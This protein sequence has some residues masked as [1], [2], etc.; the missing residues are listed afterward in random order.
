MVG[1]NITQMV[2][3]IDPS[4]NNGGSTAASR[5]GTWTV[6][7]GETT[8][9]S[10]SG[11]ITT[12]LT[13]VYVGYFD[14]STGMLTLEF[15]DP[16]TYNGGNLLLDLQHSAASWNRWYFLGVAATDTYYGYSGSQDFLPK[17]T[18]SYENP[19]AC[20][21]PSGVTIAGVTATTATISWTI[22]T[23]QTATYTITNGS[24]INETT[25]SG[26]S[27][28]TLEG[29]TPQTTYSGLTITANCGGAG[30]SEAA[31]V[32]TIRT[33]AIPVNLPYS[34]GFEAG[35]DVNWEYTQGTTNI[36]TVGS[37]TNNG[38][39]NALYISNDNGASNAYSNGTSAISYACRLFNFSQDGDYAV[40][41]DWNANGENNWDYLRA[42]LAPGNAELTADQLPDHTTGMSSYTTT[43]PDGWI[44]LGNGQMSLSTD[45]QNVQL[46]A[47][48]ITAGNYYLVFMWGNDGSGGS[49]PPAAIDNV[50][51][52]RITCPAP[53][54]LTLDPASLTAT[55]ATISWTPR[56][57]ETSWLMR[58]N[59]GTWQT[60]TAATQTLTLEPN[61]EYT[62]Q[63]RAFCGVGDTSLTISGTFRT[64]CLD[65]ATA[66]LP[67]TMGFQPSEI[68]D[69]ACWAVGS[70][71]TTYPVLTLVGHTG[72]TSLQIR[73]YNNSSYYP[74]S[75]Y[76][77]W[78]TLPKFEA[79]VNTLQMSFWMKYNSSYSSSKLRVGVMTDPSDPSTFTQIEEISATDSWTL[80]DVEFDTYTGNGNYI[81]LMVPQPTSTYT[82]YQVLVDDISVELIPAC[83]K[84]KN[85]T[86]T[87]NGTTVSTSWT[88]REGQNLWEVAV[89]AKDSTVVRSEEVEETTFAFAGLKGNTDYIVRVQ[90]NCGTDGMGTPA[91]ADVHTDPEV[92][93]IDPQH[94][95]YCR[96]EDVDQYESQ[97]VLNNPSNNTTDHWTIGTDATTTGN[98]LY[99]TDDELGTYHYTT[100]GYSYKRTYALMNVL[101]G[102]GHN[103]YE[104]SFDIKSNSNNSNHYVKVYLL[105]ASY[106]ISA[107]STPSTSASNCLAYLP[108]LYNVS[109]W[110]TLSGVFETNNEEPTQYRLVVMWY[111]YGTA[112]G[113]PAAIDNVMLKQNSCFR[114]TG[115]DTVGEPTANSITLTWT[116][117]NESNPGQWQV[118]WSENSGFDPDVAKGRSG[119]K[120]TENNP[121]VVTG[122]KHSTTYFFSVRSKCSDFSA[123][124]EKYSF[125]T[126][127]GAYTSN[128][129]PL[130]ENFDSYTSGLPACWTAVGGGN[131]QVRSGSAYSGSYKLDFRGVAGN[132]IVA[133]PVI[134]AGSDTLIM[135][136]YTKP[137]SNSYANCGQF[138]VGYITDLTDS[139]TFHALATYD[140]SDWA[141]NAY[142][143]REVNLVNLPAG[144]HPAFR[145][146]SPV[147]NYYWYVDDLNIDIKADQVVL[148]NSGEQTL[149]NSIVKPTIETSTGSYKRN[150][151]RTYVIRPADNGKALNVSGSVDLDLG[152]TL[153][154]YEGIGDNKV[155]KGEYTNTTATLNLIKSTVADWAVNNAI[156]LVFRTNGSESGIHTGFALK[157][158]C[159]CPAGKRVD[160]TG[161]EAAGHYDFVMSDGTLSLPNDNHAY[162]DNASDLEYDF[163]DVYQAVVGG[164][165]SV[166]LHHIV[167]V[168]PYYTINKDDNLCAGKTYQ[169]IDTTLATGGIYTRTG[170]T[171][172][173]ADSTVTVN[174]QQRSN[175]TI[176]LRYENM[177]VNVVNNFCEGNNMD[178]EARS[179]SS[180]VRFMW[181]DSTFGATRTVTPLGASTYTVQATDTIYGCVS[182]VATLNVTTVPSPMPVISANKTEICAGDTVVLTVSDTNN[183][184]GVT[185][186]W[187]TGETGSSIT[188]VPTTVPVTEYSV[189][190]ATA[191]CENVATKSITVNALPQVAITAS[192]NAICLGD[193][194][195]FTAETVLGYTYQWANGTTGTVNAFVP[196]GVGSL[197]TTLTVTDQKACVNTL[198]NTPVVVRPSYDNAV[199]AVECV[200]K[201]PYIFGN[202]TSTSI[203][204]LDTDGV[205]Y[206]TFTLATGCDSVVTLTFSVQDT[207][208]YNS[209]REYC[210]GT[211]FSFGDSLY[212]HDYVAT[213][214]TT[215]SYFDT[216]GACPAYYNL[217]VTVHPTYS[218]DIVNSVCDSLV[219][220]DSV[221]T[222]TGDYTQHL[223]TNYNCD[224]TVNLAL[225]VRYSNSYTDVKDVCDKLN[226]HGTTYTEPVTGPTFTTKNVAGC[227]S[228]VTLDLAVVRH[229]TVGYDVQNICQTLTYTWVNNMTYTMSELDSNIAF[230]LP[231]PNAQGCDTTAI[232]LLSLNPATDTLNLDTVRVCDEFVED[233]LGCDGQPV[234]ASFR[235]PGLYAYRVAQDGKIAYKQ[236]Y[237][238]VKT[239]V[240][241][242]VTVTACAPYKWNKT[243]ELYFRDTTVAYGGAECADTM[244]VLHYTAIQPEVRYAYD[245]ICSMED[246]T[247]LPYYSQQ[248]EAPVTQEVSV[249]DVLPLVDREDNITDIVAG[250]YR[251]AYHNDTAAFDKDDNHCY[252]YDTLV[253]TVNQQFVETLDSLF[254]CESAFT[255]STD[256]I[257]QPYYGQM[258]YPIADAAHDTVFYLTLGNGSY[259]DETGAYECSQNFSLPTTTGCDSLIKV[260]YVV[261]PTV[262]SYTDQQVESMEFTWKE[263]GKTYEFVDSTATVMTI[264]L[265]PGTRTVKRNFYTDTVVFA[266]A[267][268]HNGYEGHE[269]QCDSVLY[270]NLFI[271]D[272]IRDVLEN[273]THCNPASYVFNGQTYYESHTFTED[274]VMDWNGKAMPVRRYWIHNIGEF[275]WGDK[276][277]VS[278]DPYAANNV[279]NDTL[280]ATGDYT[281]RYAAIS[282]CDS[283][284]E[285]HF[286]K[287][288]T[289]GVALCDTTL[290]TFSVY[291]LSLDTAALDSLRALPASEY[292]HGV[293]YYAYRVD[294]ADVDTLI[295]IAF[296]KGSFEH[297]VPVAP[298]ACDL[299]TWID[300]ITYTQD[301]D[302]VVYNY[303]DVYGCPSAD[304]LFLTL[305]HNSNHSDT[306]VACDSLKWYGK[307]YDS[308]G[309]Y[310]AKY[311]ATND[312]PSVDTLHLTIN[313]RKDTLMHVVAC[314]EYVWEN[315][316][317]YVVYSETGAYIEQNDS[318]VFTAQPGDTVTDSVIAWRI[319][320]ACYT[321]DTLVVTVKSHSER[322][323]ENVVNAAAYTYGGVQYTIPAGEHDTVIGPFEYT[324]T[325]PAA[326]GCDSIEFM[327]VHLYNGVNHTVDVANHCG[328]FTWTDSITATGDTIWLGNNHIYTYLTPAER[329]AAPLGS[330][331]YFD[332]T[333]NDYVYTNPVVYDTFEDGGFRN[334][335]VLYLTLS[336][337]KVAY[338]T[339][340]VAVPLSWN[341]YAFKPAYDTTKTITLDL[342]GYT[343]DNVTKD[344]AFV[345][346]DAYGHSVGAYCDSINYITLNLR[347]NYAKDSVIVCATTDSVVFGDTT[348]YLALEMDNTA[349]TVSHLYENLV[350]NADTLTE[351]HTDLKVTWRMLIDTTVYDTACYKKTYTFTDSVYTKSVV[352]GVDN[353]IVEHVANNCDKLVYHFLTIFT[354]TTATDIDTVCGNTYEWRRHDDSVFTAS[355]RY[356][357]KIDSQ[358]FVN[359][360]KCEAIDSLIL[361]LIAEPTIPEAEEFCD[362]WTYTYFNYLTGKDSTIGPLTMADTNAG[363]SVYHIVFEY[364]YN[365]QDQLN[366]VMEGDIIFNVKNGSV[367]DTAITVI[368]NSYKFSFSDSVYTASASDIDDTLSV[369][370]VEGCDSI[371]RWDLT[372]IPFKTKVEDYTA[373][374]RFVWERNGHTYQF[375]TVTGHLYYDLTDDSVITVAPAVTVEDTIYQLN[376]T[377]NESAIGYM[378][379]TIL[380]SQNRDGFVDN[381]DRRVIYWDYT[382]FT[383]DS[384]VNAVVNVSDVP[385]T[386]DSVV[387]YT[388]EVIYNFDVDSTVFCGSEAGKPFTW[389][390]ITVN[391]PAQGQ[392][393]FMEVV[394]NEGGITEHV[395]QNR[396]FTRED[397]VLNIFD[398]VCDQLN[399]NGHIFTETR[400]DTTI[401]LYH[402]DTIKNAN[403]CDTIV[404]L[405]L[406]VNKN[407]G[408]LY[409]AAQCDSLL[410]WN[411]GTEVKGDSLW[412]Y[413][414]DTLTWSY[415]DANKCASIDS[416]ALTIYKPESKDTVV[417]LCVDAD[418]T[419]VWNA[420]A[421]PTIHTKD[422][423]VPVTMPTGVAQFKDT[424]Y[425]DVY[426]SAH[427]CNSVDT[428]YLT[429]NL[430]YNVQVDT[431]VSESFPYHFADGHDTLLIA[432]GNLVDH[433]DS[434]ANGCDS[435]VAINVHIGNTYNAVDD[436]VVCHDFTWKDD[437][438]YVWISATERA[439]HTVSGMAPLYKT[440][441]GRYVYF[442]PTYTK[443]NNF[444]TNNWDSVFVLR[445][446]LTENYYGNDEITFNVSDE[447]LNYGI[448]NETAATVLTEDYSA[449]NNFWT[450][451]TAY[452]YELHFGATVSTGHYCDSII[453]LTVN[454]HNN[455]VNAGPDAICAYEATYTWHDSTYVMRTDSAA[456]TTFDTIY[457]ND[458]TNNTVQYR[459]LTRKPVSNSVERREACDYYTWNGMPFGEEDLLGSGQTETYRNTKVFTAENGCDSIVS[460]VLTLHYNAT[461][462]TPFV[463]ACDSATYTFTAKLDTATVT[464]K[465]NASV[466][467]SLVWQTAYAGYTMKC[468]SV[469]YVQVSVVTSIDSIFTVAACDEYTWHNKTYKKDT[470]VSFGPKNNEKEFTDELFGRSTFCPVK[471]SL[472]LDIKN[473]SNHLI[474]DDTVCDFYAT[475]TNFYK[476]NL[477]NVSRLSSW[478]DADGVMPNDT[479][480]YTDGLEFDTL[481]SNFGE[482][483]TTSGVYWHLYT[484]NDGCHSIDTLILNV[485]YNSNSKPVLAEAC[486]T[487]RYEKVYPH[488]VKIGT[489]A[490]AHDTT[491]VD[492]FSFVSTQSD[493]VLFEYIALNGCPSVDTLVFTVNHKVDTTF[494][495][496]ACDTWT[497]NGHTV[498]NSK[499]YILDT[500]LVDT[501]QNASITGC[502]SIVTINLSVGHGNGVAYQTEVACGHYDWVVNDSLVGTFT[503]SINTSFVSRNGAANYCDS[504]VYLRLTIAEPGIYL[505]TTVNEAALPFVWYGNEYTEAGIYRD[506]LAGDGSNCDSIAELHLAIRN[507]VV[508]NE[509]RCF[510]TKIFNMYGFTFDSAALSVPGVISAYNADSTV[511]LNLTVGPKNTSYVT[512]VDTVACDSYDWARYVD[513]V[514]LT[515]SG[516]YTYWYLDTVNVDPQGCYKVD[517]L[518]LTVVRNLGVK[519]EVYTCSAYNWRGNEYTESGEYY[520]QFTDTNNCAAADTLVLT[521]NGAGVATSFDTAACGSFVWDGFV[522]T[523]SGSYSRTYGSVDDCDSVVTMNLTITDQVF[524]SIAKLSCGSYTWNGITYNESGTYTQ[525]FEAENGCDSVV[526]L[527]LIVGTVASGDTAA[528]A[529]GSFEWFGETYTTSGVYTHTFVADETCDSVVTLTLT[530]N[531]PVTSTETV[532]ACG[533]YTWNDVT[534]TESG[535]YTDTLTAVNGCDSIVTLNLTINEPIDII[536]SVVACDSYTWFDVAYTTS[537]TYTHDITDANGCAATATLGLTIHNSVTNTISAQNCVSYTWND[538]TYYGS[539]SYT[540]SFQTVHGCDSTVTLNLTINQPTTGSE[541]IE[542]CTDITWHGQTISTSG[543]YTYTTVNA[544]GCDSVVTLFF[545]RLQSVAVTVNATACDSYTWNGTTYTTSGTY[546]YNTTGTNGCDSLTTLVLTINE[547]RNTNIS[548]SACESYSWNDQEYTTS[549]TYQQTL[550]ARNGCDSI[551]TLTLTVNHDAYSTVTDE[552][553]GSYFWNGEEYTTSGT[554]LYITTTTAGCDSI[555][556]LNLTVNQPVYTNLTITADGS[557]NWNGEVY[558]ESGIYTYTTTAA[559]GCDSTVTLDLTVNPIYNVTLVSANETMGTVSESGAIVE[560]GYFTAVATPKEGYEF[561]EWKNGNVTVSTNATYVF[562]VT[563]DVTLTAVFQVKTVG[564]ED[565]DMDNVTIYSSNSTIYV[566][567]VEGHDV[568]V[569]DV[570]GRMMDRQLNAADAI[571]FRMTATGVYLV[572]VGNAPAKR[573][574]VV[575]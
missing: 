102:A 280:T 39:S 213:T 232:L 287:V 340:P 204:Q 452:H 565:V 114:P 415:L 516:I 177:P 317:G 241:A 518:Y 160:S 81:A 552:A 41:F 555:V 135:S 451:D 273:E 311:T 542:S 29:L 380:L 4:G 211:A 557:Y 503:E 146:R 573:V 359:G 390:G 463:V 77:T 561:V 186:T 299:F 458:T 26:A 525:T 418:Y 90:A 277:L 469:E 363:D 381:S 207:A 149:C 545:T 392:N 483:I 8:A 320:D 497:W 150:L 234:M 498:T 422:Y 464:R 492:T 350:T 257:G 107:T 295:T 568:Y 394:L 300:G 269:M 562:Q 36:W 163:N 367:Y 88:G 218:I 136:F 60:V 166:E 32:P 108:N 247:F 349:D 336:N 406:V 133:L 111:D 407:S 86:A 391:A 442:A 514:T 339:V 24:T 169:L 105:K 28:Y 543:A 550:T 71:N 548:E 89:L 526:T 419:Y 345:Y 286:T 540:Q 100:S 334:V 413:D 142:E 522:Y 569:Y 476:V 220:N 369:K 7:L 414:S 297:V 179:N 99:V 421:T 382:D 271:F 551:V 292:E 254:L 66:D 124:S 537:G 519:T 488:T 319:Y 357:L 366:C 58:L 270:L 229:S 200:D 370:N 209:F 374:G 267:I 513:T 6:S 116:D 290:R 10:L 315:Y 43:T 132:D 192:A 248:Y 434:V 1:K 17:T 501:L 471:D 205:Y 183:L 2:F 330:A 474:A 68:D 52:A 159:D 258:V 303:T 294:T 494:S 326:N 151:N 281:L 559:N 347:Y 208:T 138:D 83:R 193:S 541:T 118:A 448:H 293:H 296:S 180:A 20:S 467:D 465:Y 198:T 78:V 35:Q 325:A 477:I 430:N 76:Y 222:A 342:S 101:L 351:M 260:D 194:V 145:H 457:W 456:Y 115:L 393:D 316:A 44:D 547:T 323:W 528:T 318:L 51:I 546:T 504:T 162:D 55:S 181:D 244:Y 259:N 511:L 23:G 417:T 472:V 253:L 164:C 128:D 195:T 129:L 261:F 215:I 416:L 427:S 507:T 360:W 425:S 553:C 34:T 187:S 178:L 112:D 190:A 433:F 48:E 530:I 67:Y 157:L 356:G 352:E 535:V 27:S 131:P 31:N 156:T 140:R 388:I 210:Y 312:C 558:T 22:P 499:S 256:T 153:R 355:G 113:T 167:T 479:S 327:T 298:E 201:L 549:G 454:V 184:A 3:Y 18:F 440:S 219:W 354:P 423:D 337:V 95:Y 91:Y 335:Y 250:T 386:C 372:L 450:A 539:G 45:W 143:L 470:N 402:L 481:Y 206:N 566:K 444:A 556:T 500:V 368:G 283:I 533:S 239:T 173:G 480:V 161:I 275:V 144:A 120:M 33:T 484:N 47:D 473:R 242:P 383:N 106:N 570:N 461:D 217:Y 38:G 155:L 284:V 65:I 304:T 70:S 288:D 446:T 289:I 72:D 412:H 324:V 491:I 387:Y 321:A 191:T 197:T 62:I 12:T 575:R 15:D 396:L 199:E 202:E 152:D 437:T 196:A 92:V 54:N 523:E 212:R 5:L 567:G 486:D 246:Y 371:V 364:A 53:G 245:T 63:V 141:A 328:D 527:T 353:P 506:T 278:S 431:F 172:Y 255:L 75:N 445:L 361:T 46:S 435:T 268:E 509:F 123:W 544:A 50:S 399:F 524:D 405:Y 87:A 302:S 322:H 532:T 225:T 429:L 13:Q 262:E 14:C 341:S 57:G 56:G 243:G 249:T 237:L 61:T 189:T 40:S 571:E 560:N 122:L 487:F 395:K 127:C 447:V 276:Y 362:T 216:L 274:D 97:W 279:D 98:S 69:L 520:F 333:A 119:L 16:Y 265:N 126:A 221:Y 185:F 93:T 401:G 310:T 329:T 158:Q 104:Y 377:L 376:L 531:Q 42:W 348:L 226:W 82:Y 426:A 30:S 64:P 358:E 574:V 147:T 252:I 224:S 384:V 346:E 176:A 240:V 25:A 134:N 515:E 203:Q 400:S 301:T 49:Q 505:D 117:N 308:T 420:T 11:L 485:N 554:Y 305:M 19:P 227:D 512:S 96:F 174:L 165:D 130:T 171:I 343:R 21:K 389:E 534:L 74:S 94:P 490:S 344:T 309:V 282:G 272:T 493:S 139:A 235:N 517:S 332:R 411:L 439:E 468:R 214:D 466:L 521:I 572:K 233:T 375:D 313:T 398:T 478:M 331:L 263:N 397:I 168:H 73:S 285:M 432:D 564:I 385:G 9:T 148:D 379:T 460:L 404:H 502:D 182:P 538:Q 251:I 175:P 125:S 403:M 109:D 37:A 489:G 365:T 236:I 154:I 80:K 459:I 59:D 462:T 338:D 496:V 409:A 307:W 238:Q 438:T 85:L 230:K 103:Q 170:T 449:R 378:T 441:T 508:V 121:Y 137:E 373:C 79:P 453:N 536:A 408:H 436:T 529:C 475:T 424:L 495:A 443:H 231:V 306:I 264:L 314:D 428:L 510:G 84:V 110:Q 563:E 482:D 228:V 291:G 455:Y 188:V 410:W 223:L 266:N